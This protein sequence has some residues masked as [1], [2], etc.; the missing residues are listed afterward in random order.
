MKID[1]TDEYLE[2]CKECGAFIQNAKP[3]EVE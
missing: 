1:I 3:L 2:K